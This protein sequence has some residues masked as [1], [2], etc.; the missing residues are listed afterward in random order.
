MSEEQRSRKWLVRVKGCD[1]VSVS[2]SE[3]LE[4]G[5]RPIRPL[6]DDGNP[7]FEVPDETRSMSKR[8]AVFSVAVNGSATLRDMH[9]TNGTYMVRDDGQLIR[10]PADAEFPLP[11]TAVRMQF[12][13]VPVDFVMVDEPA[14]PEPEQPVADL[15]EYAVG[16][17]K[18]EPDASGLSV[19]DILD[20]RAGEPTSMFDASSVSRRASELKAA[21]LRSFTPMRP[22]REEPEGDG[23]PE[24][25]PLNVMP[26]PSREPRDL[27]ADAMA[28]SADIPDVGAQPFAVEPVEPPAESSVLRTDAGSSAD[29]VMPISVIAQRPH[30][31]Q[32]EPQSTNLPAAQSSIDQHVAQTAAEQRFAPVVTE[33]PIMTG[34]PVAA[35]DSTVGASDEP[36]AVAAGED[37]DDVATA[38][39]TAND[40]A[41]ETAPATDAPA[42]DSTAD[43]DAA[44]G[45]T[46][47]DKTGDEREPA[48]EPETAEP[49]PQDAFQQP[50]AYSPE[51]YKPAFEP[52]SVFDRVSK[53][54]FRKAEPAVEVNGFTS[55]DAKRTTDFSTQFAMAR[56]PQL[57]PF[58][59]MNPSLYDDLYAWL[60]AQG[61]ADVDAAL[62]DNPGYQDYRKAAGK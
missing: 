59:A 14:E 5:R 54:E 21:S 10:L 31:A 36:A 55:D 40:V 33:Q 28:D 20:L 25:V 45:D 60:V 3:S 15:F 4:I 37:A 34:Q 44:D 41:L 22:I 43:D 39:E 42:V 29:R 2:P 30:H 6:A 23:M 12:G 27:F 61:N 47:S 16:D 56:Y 9:S 24:T 19:D 50:A 48:D 13:D 52:G 49:Q 1:Q 18:P 32:D 46:A 26:V 38:D 62:A 11:S 57:L 8:H 17:A 35:Q 51:P 7:R 58:L 53:G